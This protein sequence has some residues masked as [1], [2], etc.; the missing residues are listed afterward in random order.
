[1]RNQRSRAH[2][3]HDFL[4]LTKR[5]CFLPSE[6]EESVMHINRSFESVTASAQARRMSRSTRR[7]F[8]RRMRFRCVAL[9][10]ALQ[11]LAVS[12]SDLS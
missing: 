1:V 11:A 7:R 4:C 12:G 6:F 10:T 2:K 9:L 8:A 3:V 5:W